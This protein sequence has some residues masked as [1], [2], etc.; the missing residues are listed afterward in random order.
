MAINSALSSM[1]DEEVALFLTSAKIPPV[2][3]KCMIN[4]MSDKMTAILRIYPPSAGGKETSKARI[5]E[6]LMHMKVRAGIDEAAI[7]SALD[8]RLY[9]TDIVV[10]QGK[11]PAPGRDGSIVYHFDTDNT[12][13][14]ELKEDGTVDFFKLNNLHQCTKG[15]VLAEIIPEERGR[16]DL[17]CTVPSCWRVR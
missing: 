1:G 6:L 16:T 9:C 5:L 13:R 12:V 15:Q 8:E 10:A 3:E 2:D 7:Q 14:P 17:M 11:L 4:V